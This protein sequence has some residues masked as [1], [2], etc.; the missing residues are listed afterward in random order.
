MAKPFDM[1]AIQR[2]HIE[3]AL[4]RLEQ[5]KRN[6][7]ERANRKAIETRNRRQKEQREAKA[8]KRKRPSMGT[9]AERQKLALPGWQ[10]LIARMDD[11]AWHTMGEMRALVPEYA[12]GTVKGWVQIKLP[13]NG[14]MERA[15]NPDF[16]D[17][18]PAKAMAT[19]LMLYRLTPK[20]LRMA[21]EWREALGEANP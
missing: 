9:N 10:V 12:K 2:K 1:T 19:G 17:S 20:A 8:A 15:G 13:N 6:R 14:W 11:D 5:T 7:A 16:D 3:R 18:D 21:Q 4:A